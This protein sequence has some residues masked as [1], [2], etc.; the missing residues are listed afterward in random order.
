MFSRAAT[1]LVVALGLFSLS[2]GTTRGAQPW[3]DTYESR[4]EMLALLQTVNGEILAASSATATLERWCREHRMAA[5]PA[6]VAQRV[7]GVDKAPSDDQLQRLG[8]S[9]RSAVKYRRVR[10]QCGAH[11]FSEADNWYVPARLT[12]EM[13]QLLDTSDVPFGK[14]VRELM[15]YRRTLEARLLWSPLPAL[16]ELQRRRVGAGRGSLVIPK[17]VLVHTAVLY[18]ADH[19]PFSLVVETY[20]A[21]SSRSARAD[22]VSKVERRGG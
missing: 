15:P 18:T 3:R 20:Q 4:L 12:P 19:Q 10:L 14:V 2:C 7:P 8:V 22:R 1:L 11:T 16:W 17:E 5:Q 21:S 13:N 9:D 6:I